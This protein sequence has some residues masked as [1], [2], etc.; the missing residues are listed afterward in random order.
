[1][2]YLTI[3]LNFNLIEKH[4]VSMLA[5][6]IEK[7]LNLRSLSL[8][9]VCCLIGDSEI[10]ILSISISKIHNLNH[11]EL[12]LSNNIINNAEVISIS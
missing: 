2:T 11:L 3:R 4:G 9:L 1:M 6:C 7:L 10:E 8:S 12:I 5:G